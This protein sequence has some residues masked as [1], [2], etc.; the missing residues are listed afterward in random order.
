MC[1][2]TA[3]VDLLNCLNKIMLS[4]NFKKDFIYIIDRI[5]VKKENFAFVR[6]NEGEYA[7]TIGKYFLGAW[8]LW[9]TYPESKLQKDLQE[10]LKIESKDYVY[11]IASRQHSEAN[12]WYKENI[13]GSKSFATLFVNH[14]RRH[15]KDIIK[16]INES[17]V[18]VANKEWMFKDYPFKVKEFFWVP[19]DVVSLY[20][21]QPEI[22]S[23]LVD[24]ITKNKNKLIFF[25]AG[26][27]SNI[28]IYKCWLK[29]PHNRYIDV[30]STLDFYIH[31]EPSRRYFFENSETY[32]QIDI[33]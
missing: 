5:F 16:R 12:D 28:L 11:W 23:D 15:F 30:W 2:Q 20:E 6:F 26:P 10:S 14:N 8:G 7:L 21:N 25:C 17:V 3:R 31:W 18:L 29:N 22:I 4:K 19:F 13:P 27:L 32:D 33:F 9:R 24:K 1:H